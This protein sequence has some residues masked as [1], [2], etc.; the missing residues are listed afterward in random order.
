MKEFLCKKRDS[1][2]SQ[3]VVILNEN[4][5]VV[6][7]HNLPTKIKNPGTFIIPC[8]VGLK[9][10]ERALCDSVDSISSMPLTLFK[11][12]GIETLKPTPMTLQ[13]AGRTIKR[14]L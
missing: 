5:S 6:V 12:L 10:E 14:P 1:G 3:R 2:T 8:K 13:F 11:K 7:Q 9:E 4:C